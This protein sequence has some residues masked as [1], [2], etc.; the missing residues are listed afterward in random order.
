MQDQMLLQVFAQFGLAGLVGFLLGLEREMSAKPGSYIGIRDFVFIALLGATSAFIAGQYANAWVIVAVFAG[1]IVILTTQYWASHGEDTGITTEV[2]AVLTFLLGVL[3]IMEATELAIAIAIV[4]STIL[5]QKEMIRSLKTRIQTYE[6]GA[7]LKFLVISF[8]ILPV[9]PRQTLDTYISIPVG[10][11]TAIDAGAR[12]VEI[13]MAHGNVLV[14]DQ[15]VRLYGQNWKAT[16][17]ITIVWGSRESA[18]G[19]YSGKHFNNISE[20][21]IVR[22][23]FGIDFINTA[24]SALKLYKLW[25]IVVL[26][27]FIS[28]IG[29]VLIKLIGGGAGIGL[30]GLVGGLVSSTVTTLSFARRSMESPGLNK[31]FAVAV[32]LASSIMFPRLLVEISVVNLTLMKSMALPILV[33]GLTGLCIAGYFF[34]RSQRAEPEIQA[35]QFDNPFSLKSSINFALV[36]ALILVITR[37]ATTYL[38][39]AW[40]PLVAIVSGLTD[41][42][43]IAFS[44]S[45]AQQAGMITT[46]WASFNL[47][48]GAL[49]NTFMKLL[50]VFTLGHRSLFK[51]LLISFIIIGAAG[52]IT[53]VFYYDMSAMLT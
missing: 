16:G 36:F 45:D 5:F 37:L 9:L 23:P 49:S 41:A 17:D 48:L 24:L 31:S 52:I 27:S 33:M 32:I 12:Q 18:V 11:V 7:V 43:A 30:T 13:S 6:L 8:I 28:F 46:E 19:V 44:I 20:G 35:M 22:I 26:V 21:N 3:L 1:V 34:I 39:N 14:P 47:V 42:D 38:G 40:L 15:Q 25:L 29:Y 10:E 50:L 53:M 51:H 4:A 2:A